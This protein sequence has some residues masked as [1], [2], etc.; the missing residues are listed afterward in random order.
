QVAGA[1]DG[2]HG[3]ALAADERGKPVLVDPRGERKATPTGAL[4]RWVAEFLVAEAVGPAL[5]ER[6]AAYRALAQEAAARRERLAT[7]PP[8]SAPRIEREAASLDDRAVEALLGARVVDLAMGGGRLLALAA[9]LVTRRLL[10][11]LAEDA[12][13]PLAARVA[14]VRA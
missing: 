3:L 11:L 14:E 5:D 2:I 6:E 1:L 12:G 13:G 7:A 9:E 4:P 10:A 8:E